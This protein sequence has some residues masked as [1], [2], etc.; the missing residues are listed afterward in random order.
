MVSF[1]ASMIEVVQR[2][3]PVYAVRVKES[4]REGGVLG[5]VVKIGKKLYFAGG[6]SAYA[7]EV[8][9]QLLEEASV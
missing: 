6:A 1:V 8:K 5:F 9:K 4:G 2:V 7:E 3:P